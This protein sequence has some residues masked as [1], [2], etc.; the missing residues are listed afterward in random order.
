MII[1]DVRVSFINFD[2]DRNTL[3]NIYNKDRDKGLQFD[4]LFRLVYIEI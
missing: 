1:K 2:I 3:Y 4:K